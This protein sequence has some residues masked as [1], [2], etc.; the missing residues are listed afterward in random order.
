V[1]WVE[2]DGT[3][4]Y[5]T[6]EFHDQIADE[7]EEFIETRGDKA[8]DAFFK[9]AKGEGTLLN[10]QVDTWLAEQG[11]TITAQTAAQH[12]T[13]IRAF[14]AWAGSAVL[15]EDVTRRYAGEF[16]SHLLAAPSG[17]SR[18]TARRYVSSLSSF[19]RSLRARGFA[20]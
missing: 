12:R 19:W 16:V 14:T 1:L 8:A 10:S 18:K 20:A 11:V 2:P 5:A 17:L 9:V 3:R 15:I 4:Y 13:V 6:D 7:V